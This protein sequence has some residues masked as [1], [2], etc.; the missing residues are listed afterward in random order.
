MDVCGVSPI[1]FVKFSHDCGCWYGG[2]GGP[3]FA[4]D[5]VTV[6]RVPVDDVVDDRVVRVDFDGVSDGAG[7]GVEFLLLPPAV[8]DGLSAVL[9]PLQV[10]VAGLLAASGSGT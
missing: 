9:L 8:V 2:R 1:F 10:L 6:G 7:C 5:G 4:V 3:A